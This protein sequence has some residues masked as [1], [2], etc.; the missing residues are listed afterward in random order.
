M[1]VFG[2]TAYAHIPNQFKCKFD[3]KSEKCIM[4]G[5]TNAGYRLYN[6]LKQKIIAAR[7]VIFNE[8]DFHYKAETVSIDISRTDE[9]ATD[10]EGVEDQNGQEAKGEREIHEEAHE[11]IGK[12]KQKLP[13][14]FMDYEMYM[15][16]DAMS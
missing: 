10:T 14:R 13:K 8:N 11:E 9:D 3:K 12:R 1:R 15:A 6:I 7:D 2:S 4:I 16:F 5:Y